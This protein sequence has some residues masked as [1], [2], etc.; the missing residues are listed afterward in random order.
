MRHVTL[1][2]LWTKNTWPAGPTK[3]DWPSHGKR[4]LL[5]SHGL[6]QPRTNGHV[7]NQK[8]YCYLFLD[9]IF[10]RSTPLYTITWVYLNISYSVHQQPNKPLLLNDPPLPT[11]IPY[12]WQQR[13]TL[14]P[15]LDLATCQ[16]SSMIELFWAALTMFPFPLEKNRWEKLSDLKKPTWKVIASILLQRD[17][18]FDLTGTFICEYICRA[19][20]TLKQEDYRAEAVLGLSSC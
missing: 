8:L 19:R 7:G 13:N 20:I 9:T 17:K 18:T 5:L 14:F 4:D 2:L 16:N 10:S 12:H 3:Q 6:S 1:C 11:Q 15:D